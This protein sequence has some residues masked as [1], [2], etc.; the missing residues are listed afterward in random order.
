MNAENRLD[1]SRATFVATPDKAWPRTS[2]AFPH[3]AHRLSA[4]ATRFQQALWLVALLAGAGLCPGPERF[5]MAS[6]AAA[7]EEQLY[8]CGMHPQVIRNK[9]GDCPICGMKLT[10]VRKQALTGST[11]GP[12]T[13][14]SAI[15]IDPVTRQNMGLRTA[16][17][18]RGPLRRTVR[19]V[20]TID[21]DETTLADVTT[22][23]KG[24]ITALHVNATG[25]LVH[26]GDPLFEINAPELFSAQAEFLAMLG[27]GTTPAAGLAGL[28]ASALARLRYFDISDDQIAELRKTRQP[29]RT[30]RVDAPRDGT[31]VEKL[32][33]EGQ[34]VEEG[35]K[36]YRIADLGLLWVQAQVFEQDLPLVRVGQE[37]LISVSYLNDR[38]FR[39]RVTFIA[40]TVDDKTRTVRVR[41]EVHN[42]GYFLK[43]GMFATVELQAEL[44]S[45]AV[46]IP[47]TAILRSGAKNTVFVALEGGRFA[48]RPITLGPRGEDNRYQVLDGVTAGERVVVSGQFMLDSESQLREAIQKMETPQAAAEVAQPAVAPADTGQQA[49]PP[50]LPG[51]VCP[52]PEHVA[53]L[54]TQPGK[55]PICG[56]ALVPASVDFPQKTAS[57]SKVDH[58]TCPMPEHGDVTSG[59]PGKCPRCGMTLIP[60]MT[61]APAPAPDGKGAP[62]AL[63]TCPMAEDADVVSDQPGQCPKCGMALVKTGTVKH[64]RIAEEHWQSNRPAAKPGAET[65]RP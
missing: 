11:E 56:M 29:R 45:D 2:R 19:T 38:K 32:A 24:W 10:P 22:K 26:R 54:Y 57:E 34:M 64:G 23:F 21:F 35:M 31:V 59:K 47:D 5:D 18:T 49:A 14:T 25:Q 42:P 37:A 9:P 58:Y 28:Q 53:I 13:E 7:A 61:A 50:P 41:L 46:L 27:D 3:L 15:S 20:A 4:A 51:Y 6:P 43:P 55:C 44:A 8:T 36:L 1:K 63:Y 39:G 12:S 60:V 65:G 16:L 33:V 52:M 62:A 17:V 48:P 40:P 30:L